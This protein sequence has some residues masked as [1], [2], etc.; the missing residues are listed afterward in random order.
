MDAYA[1]SKQ[2]N[3]ATVFSLAREHPRLRFRA[4]EPGVNP[5]S[6]L[7]ELPPALRLLAKALSPAL[8]LVP[9]FTTSKRAA[10]VITRIVTDA[11]TESGTYYDENGTKMRASAQVSDPAFSDR[12]VRESRAL[13]ESVE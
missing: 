8:T 5:G 1:T 3:L 12:Y 13:L 7:G 9:H 11:S 10:R 4:I 6:N 2:G